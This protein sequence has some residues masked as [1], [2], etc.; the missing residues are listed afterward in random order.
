VAGAAKG[1]G[2]SGVAHPL[3]GLP[4]DVRRGT[5]GMWL[6]IATEASLFVML[7]FAYFYLSRN[8]PLWPPDAPP[9]LRMPLVMLGVLASSS[10]V[11][12]WGERTLRAGNQVR[13][14]L[15]L[16]VT[17]ALGLLFLA[18]QATEYADKWTRL[19]PSTNA[20]GSIF[21]V[22]TGVHGCHVALGICMLAYVALLPDLESPDPP[23]RAMHNASLYWH[24]VDVVWVVI[25]AI[26]YVL[27]HFTRRV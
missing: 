20:Y 15:S 4:I 27:P 17:V 21:Y 5:I 9:S 2:M 16:V 3:P 12:F 23:H 24:F 1:A 8:V 22:I 10:I 25:V 6:F 13:A 7:F 19:R 11:L 14:R 26:I 18:I